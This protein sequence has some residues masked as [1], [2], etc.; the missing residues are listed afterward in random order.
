[1][2]EEVAGTDTESDLQAGSVHIGCRLRLEV[3]ARRRA[4]PN[5][6]IELRLGA[7]APLLE[8]AATPERLALWAR[9]GF[10]QFRGR[11]FSV[12]SRKLRVGFRAPALTSECIGVRA[13]LALRR[14]GY[15]HVQRR[16]VRPRL[17]G[18]GVSAGLAPPTLTFLLWN[19]AGCDGVVKSSKAPIRGDRRSRVVPSPSSE[20]KTIGEKEEMTLLE[21]LG[22]IQR[23]S[24]LRAAVH[25]LACQFAAAPVF[26]PAGRSLW[27]RA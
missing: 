26:D 8:V 9:F 13:A 15:L 23:K 14:L 21:I 2:L 4:S 27:A 16:P 20:T 10:G 19:Q 3:E 6:L 12:G 1:M 11:V 18:T 22:E 7:K 5:R 17:E 24:C 25:A